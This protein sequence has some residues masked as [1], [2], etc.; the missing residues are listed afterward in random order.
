[1]LLLPL[2]FIPTH[3]SIA[4][5]LT[6]RACAQVSILHVLGVVVD[7][8]ADDEHRA[9]RPRARRARAR[10]ACAQSSPMCASWLMLAARPPASF[11]PNSHMHPLHAVRAVLRLVR[12]RAA[13]CSM[14]TEGS[15]L[16]SSG[17]SPSGLMELAAAE[18]SAADAQL[19]V[20]ARSSCV[21]ERPE[22][23]SRLVC[24]L[25]RDLCFRDY[26]CLWRHQLL[27]CACLAGAQGRLG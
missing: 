20:A 19:L 16:A 9:L 17:C 10:A 25:E 12:K 7:L 4:H 24:G 2:S 8:G 13:S 21:I 22:L 18:H 3:V 5:S 1:M 27:F 6:T 11:V 15:A 26:G 14:T 23:A